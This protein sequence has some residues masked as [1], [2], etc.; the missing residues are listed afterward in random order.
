MKF[1]TFWDIWDSIFKSKAIKE[2]W[3]EK[4]WNSLVITDIH[5]ANMII[6]Q[7]KYSNPTVPKDKYFE[8]KT[9]FIFYKFHKQIGNGIITIPSDTT[10]KICQYFIRQGMDYEKIHNFLIGNVGQYF[11]DELASNIYSVTSSQFNSHTQ[12]TKT[13]VIDIDKVVQDSLIDANKM[14]RFDRMKKHEAQSIIQKMLFK[15]TVT[16]GDAIEYVYCIGDNSDKYNK[17]GKS[18]NPSERLKQLQT[19][20]PTQLYLKYSAK[21][22]N[23]KFAEE[24]L[25]SLF[26][27]QN[28][29]INGNKEWFE[30]P[31]WK[32]INE[33]R[34]YENTS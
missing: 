12:G 19:G 17:I 6:N 22:N 25:H 5:T 30:V 1:I 9:K 8:A 24:E 31:S 23:S 7:Y 27:S 2:T 4:N 11:F 21:V 34:K 33:I 26:V 28:V 16:T 10:G 15:D 3:A 14:Y 18:N 13:F 32:I 20:N 29:I